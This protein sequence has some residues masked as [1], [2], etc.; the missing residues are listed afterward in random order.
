[1]AT[2]QGRGDGRI[3]IVFAAA[4]RYL[5]LRGGHTVGHTVHCRVT[6]VRVRLRYS[7]DTTRRGDD[8][9]NNNAVAAPMI[10]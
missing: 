1:M 3:V 6:C 2:A 4:R 7:L 8:D 5:S 9:N 10:V